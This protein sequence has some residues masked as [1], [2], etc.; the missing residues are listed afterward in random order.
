MRAFVLVLLDGFGTKGRDNPHYD[1]QAAGDNAC[2]V[3]DEG[4]LAINHNAA[5]G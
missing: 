3:Y 1:V 4:T 2:K 5:T